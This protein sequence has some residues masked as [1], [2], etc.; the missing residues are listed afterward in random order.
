MKE[1]IATCNIGHT[2]CSLSFI[3]MG[4]VAELFHLQK[5]RFTVITVTKIFSMILGAPKNSGALG[6]SL[7]ALWLIRPCAYGITRHCS[8]TTPNAIDLFLSRLMSQF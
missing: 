6:F 5:P 1:D 7:L 3:H 8:C 4:A 2:S